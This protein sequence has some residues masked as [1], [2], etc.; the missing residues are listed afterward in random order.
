[1]SLRTEASALHPHESFEVVSHSHWQNPGQGCS[2]GEQQELW[3][4][5]RKDRLLGVSCTAEGCRSHPAGA[6][7]IQLKRCEPS[8][9]LYHYFST[10]SNQGL[11]ACPRSRKLSHGAKPWSWWIVPL[12][13]PPWCPSTAQPSPQAAIS[14]VLKGSWMDPLP[15]LLCLHLTEEWWRQENPAETSLNMSCTGESGG[16]GSWL[17]W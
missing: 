11:C 10:Y 5:E 1:M 17:Q 12:C 14:L 7:S 4:C 13:Y 8:P 6:V 16:R 9:E 2:N 15:F 3:C